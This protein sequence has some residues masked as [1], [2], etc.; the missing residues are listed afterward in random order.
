MKLHLYM[1]IKLLQELIR[2]SNLG[3]EISIM[4]KDM[5]SP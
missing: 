4:Q 5:V 3:N 1:F 2:T